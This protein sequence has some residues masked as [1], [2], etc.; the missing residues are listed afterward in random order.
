MIALLSLLS[1]TRDDGIQ[2]PPA[3][4]IRLPRI[5]VQ[6]PARGVFVDA[7][8]QVT[9]A[10]KITPGSAPVER[11]L[12]NGEEIELGVDLRFSVPL[13]PTPGVNV[14]GLRV[15]DQGG[16]RA[17]EGLSFHYAGDNEPGEV[18]PDAVRMVIGP[19]LLDDDD[20]DLD[21]VA[22]IVEVL[23]EDPELTAGIVGTT[24]EES[25]YDIVVTGFSFDS[26]DI[27]IDPQ[28][29]ELPL[30]ATLD[31]VVL[32]FDVNG[33]GAYSWLSTS[34]QGTCSEVLVYVTLEPT[35]GVDIEV[36]DADATMHDFALE[37]DWVPGF[38]ESWIEGWAQETI[39]EE[40][41][42]TV[43]EMADGVLGEYLSSFSTSLPLT[44]SSE[45]TLT[46]SSLDVSPDG[47]LL[48]LDGLAQGWGTT[49]P[50]NA[51]SLRSTAAAPDWPID[52]SYPFAVAIDDD[53]VDQ[54]LFAFW[55]TGAL[56]I[57]FGAVEVAVL[58]GGEPLPP[59]LGPVA[60]VVLD[61]GLPPVIRPGD[62]EH[63]MKLQLGEFV[64][65]IA[66]EDGV[67]VTASINVVAGGDLEQQ[68]GALAVVL[69]DR[70]AYI[71]VDVGMLATPEGLD[72]GD[73]ASLFRLMTPTL[74]GSA[75]GFM[76]TM[77]LPVIP[78]GD[79][80]A[81]DELE[82]KGLLIQDAEVEMLESGWLTVTGE[83]DIVTVE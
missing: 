13:E 53:L 6:S 70:P 34:G 46:L 81:V 47:L 55:A 33:K 20:P 32:D 76:P 31:D 28:E 82:G 8:Q 43:L 73:L 59:P 79:L 14:V 78:V 60:G 19:E 29:G 36:T 45:V 7:G 68:D 50:N 24:I 71:D 63:G 2:E 22:A 52:R 66:R 12:L 48:T 15:E 54:V 10:G 26:A 74:L 1:C 30:L 18:I 80:F 35:G 72:P 3:P 39:E 27:D 49:L 42:S 67:A 69:D 75:A 51:G 64:M 61:I 57:E 17:V 62:D 9:L 37:I 65:D 21:D 23:V 44:S 11:L 25:S 40:L 77:P 41:E 56:R 4:I 38:I 16:E 5:E 58:S 83:V